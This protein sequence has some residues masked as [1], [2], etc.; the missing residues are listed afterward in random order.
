MPYEQA[1]LRLPMTWEANLLV[2][3][4][5]ILILVGAAIVGSFGFPVV[6]C[7]QHSFYRHALIFCAHARSMSQN[8]TGQ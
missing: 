2:G 5:L 8:A 1:N 6:G 7:F 4:T 3:I